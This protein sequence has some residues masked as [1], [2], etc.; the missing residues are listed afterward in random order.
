MIEPK[1]RPTM[2]YFAIKSLIKILCTMEPLVLQIED[3]QRIDDTSQEALQ[4][5]KHQVEDVRFIIL[6]SSRYNDDGSKPTLK[7]DDDIRQ[8]A[9]VLEGVLNPLKEKE[10]IDAQ[11]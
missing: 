5:L 1:D 6:L 3:I 10:S 7:C 4:I 9:V 2:I 11:L 8:R